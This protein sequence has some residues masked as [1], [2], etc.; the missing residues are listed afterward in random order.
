MVQ[1]SLICAAVGALALVF[2]GLLTARVL[3]LPAGTE[4]MQEIARAIQ[5]GARAYL[6]RQYRT[7]AVF[8]LLIFALLWAFVGTATA[9]SFLAGAACSAVAWVPLW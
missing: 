2:A 6:N 1:V 4:R 3:R 8:A 9:V 7:I 5:E